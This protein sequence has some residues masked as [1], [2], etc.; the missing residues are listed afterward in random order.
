[1]VQASLFSRSAPTVA[2][3][4]HQGHQAASRAAA[5]A[6]ASVPD[7]TA[8]AAVY[9]LA[10]AH[11]MTDRWLVEDARAYAEDQGCPPP[12]DPRAWGHVARLLERRGEIRPDGYR[13]SRASHGSP[14]VAWRLR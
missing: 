4:R 3:A 1:M 2:R 10:F 13:P 6:D 5:R 12:P 8:R 11:T 9:V 14:K 7:W